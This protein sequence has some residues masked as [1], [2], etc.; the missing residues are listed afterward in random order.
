MSNVDACEVK[1]V[2]E[3]LSPTNKLPTFTMEL[4]FHVSI[5]RDVMLLKKDFLRYITSYF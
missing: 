2:D 4:E 5:D 3:N 1:I